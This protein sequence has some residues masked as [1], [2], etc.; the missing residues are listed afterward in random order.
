[1]I[2]LI[3]KS[4]PDLTTIIILLV[5]GLFILLAISMFIEWLM[6]KPWKKDKI[7]AQRLDHGNIT[8]VGDSPS[9]EESGPIEKSG[10]VSQA[11]IA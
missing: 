10:Y 8:E 4:V 1:M 5:G 2:L 6:S 3:Q 11:G 7:E 9:Q